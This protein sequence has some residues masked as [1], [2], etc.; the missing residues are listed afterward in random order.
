MSREEE[1]E[2]YGSEHNLDTLEAAR[3]NTR[4]VGYKLAIEVSCV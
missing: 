4:E 3:N 2:A 1:I